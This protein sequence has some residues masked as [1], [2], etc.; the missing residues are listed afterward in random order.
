MKEPQDAQKHMCCLRNNFAIC[1]FFP[2]NFGRDFCELIP[3]L[4]KEGKPRSGGVVCSK[5][6]LSYRAEHGVGLNPAASACFLK[7][8][9]VTNGSVR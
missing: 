6:L 9:L 4:S 8:E 3:L 2:Q 7:F 1:C 5:F